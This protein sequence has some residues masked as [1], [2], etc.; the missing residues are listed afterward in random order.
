MKAK[1]ENEMAKGEWFNRSKRLENGT[2]VKWKER[3]LGDGEVEKIYEG[4][5]N[6]RLSNPAPVTVREAV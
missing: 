4:E 6:V 2:I 5:G 1:E 3:S